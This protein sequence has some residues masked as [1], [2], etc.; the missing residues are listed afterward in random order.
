MIEYVFDQIFAAQVGD[1]LE[2]RDG[3]KKP[4]TQLRVRYENA[5]CRINGKW[6]WMNGCIL[7]DGETLDDIV[8]IHKRGTVG[9]LSHEERSRLWDKME[10]Y[11]ID[12]FSNLRGEHKWTAWASG[13]IL[14]DGNGQTRLEAVAKCV[15]AIEA[16]ENADGA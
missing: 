1:V 2:L 11:H 3:S 5:D 14:A 15:A 13:E 9:A 16:K 12:V 7:K 10:E 6:Y 8:A 4:I